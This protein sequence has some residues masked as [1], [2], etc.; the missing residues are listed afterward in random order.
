[1]GIEQWPEERYEP[2]AEDLDGES[3]GVFKAPPEPQW[4]RIEI[5]KKKDPARDEPEK[6]TGGYGSSRCESEPKV[7]RTSC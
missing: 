6:S 7:S 4:G 1:M 5:R 3:D 2:G